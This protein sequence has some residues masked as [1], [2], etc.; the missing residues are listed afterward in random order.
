MTKISVYVKWTGG[1]LWEPTR[2]CHD[3][4]RPP[5]DLA[6][7][8]QPAIA[9]IEISSA[10]VRSLS[11]LQ[12]KGYVSKNLCELF[13]RNGGSMKSKHF[14]LQYSNLTTF[15]TFHINNVHNKKPIMYSRHSFALKVMFQRIYVNYL[16]GMVSQ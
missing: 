12:Q 15:Q 9:T 1:C 4:R 10:A 16:E 14:V 3:Q 13:G 8:Q 7:C 2:G 6:R 11:H 5:W